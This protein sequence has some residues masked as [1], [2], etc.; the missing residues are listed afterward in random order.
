MEVTSQTQVLKALEALKAASK[1]IETNSDDSADCNS[2]SMKA[3]LELHT[4]SD[5]LL[6]GDPKLTTLSSLLSRLKSLASSLNSSTHDGRRRGV[7]LASLLRRRSTDGEGGEISRVAGSI[8]SELQSWIDRRSIDWLI[9]SA[10]SDDEKTSLL[11]VLESRLA[12]GFDRGFQDLLLRS[13]A[14]AAVE[15]LLSD[16]ASSKSVRE[17]SAAA[18]LAFV[19]FN[20][21]VFVGEVLMGPTA[22]S[23]VSI[24]SPTSLRVL[25]GLIA[26]IRS[27]LVDQLYADGEIGRIVSLLSSASVEVSVAAFETVLEMGY[28]GRKEAVDEMLDQGVVEKLVELQRSELGGS[29]MEMEAEREGQGVK[30]GGVRRRRE[31]RESRFMEGHPLASCVARFW[32]Q[33]EV[34]EGLRQREKRALKLEVLRRSKEAAGSDAVG[35]TIVAEVLWGS[36]YW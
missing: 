19:R 27:P 35:A 5:D 28:F 10:T 26:A 4:G 12:Q 16:Q 33:L 9:S 30:V 2:P 13:N 24:A 22:R 20:K 3:L 31:E 6:S 1:D 25:N 14:F 18:I 7:G 17:R 15:S 32:V 11:A 34:G 21:D 29:L 36:T 23:L 8:G